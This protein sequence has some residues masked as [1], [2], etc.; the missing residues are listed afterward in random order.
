[1]LVAQLCPTLCVPMDYS[2]L[3][4]EFSRQQHWNGLP[5]PSSEISSTQGLN[6]SF[7]HCRQGLYNMSHQ[8]SSFLSLKLLK[9]N[10]AFIFKNQ[11][12]LGFCHL[13]HKNADYYKLYCTKYG[14]D[15]LR[16]LLNLVIKTNWHKN[17]GTDSIWKQL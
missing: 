8:G 1:M 17:Y 16:I 13:N 7:L 2:P 6:L 15:T 11:L 12:E 9:T 10:S 4:M 5:F 14:A 3:S